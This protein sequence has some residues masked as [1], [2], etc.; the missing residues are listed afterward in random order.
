MPTVDWNR[1]EWLR[2][3]TDGHNGLGDRRSHQRHGFAQQE[4]LHFVPHL[5]ERVTM[6]ERKR[7]LGR[8]IGTPTI[9]YRGCGYA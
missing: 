5:G 7:G 8:V 4:D 2:T 6:Q 9:R 1:F 3:T